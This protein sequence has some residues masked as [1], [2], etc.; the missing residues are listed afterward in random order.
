M[1]ETSSQFYFFTFFLWAI[2][3]CS[4]DRWMSDEGYW[5]KKPNLSKSSAVHV[6]TISVR[7]IRSH[8]QTFTSKLQRLYFY[9]ASEPENTNFT[10]QT[11]NFLTLDM[12]IFVS[13]SGLDSFIISRMTMGKKSQVHGVCQSKDLL[14]SSE[15]NGGLPNLS[16]GMLIPKLKQSLKSAFLPQR[17]QNFLI[18]S[19]RK[20]CSHI[21]WSM[22]RMLHGMIPILYHNK[23]EIHHTHPHRIPHRDILS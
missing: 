18:S 16:G 23:Y 3:H 12:E 10:N 17:Y 2:K 19:T 20:P 15:T 8:F 9:T 4:L 7:G 5:L 14:S 1:R 21:L 6:A 22:R 13:F 11:S